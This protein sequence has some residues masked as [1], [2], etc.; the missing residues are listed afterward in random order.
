LR[1]D[2]SFLE[3]LEKTI[4]ENHSIR[5]NACKRGWKFRG[6]LRGKGQTEQAF[7]QHVLDS[8]VN[9]PFER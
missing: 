9:R 2:F 5:P 4:P 6:D 1:I 7:W 8:A 3:A